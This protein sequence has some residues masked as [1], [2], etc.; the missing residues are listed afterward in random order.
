M[1]MLTHG[2]SAVN[3]FA[4]FGKLANFI[5]T[6]RGLHDKALGF[7]LPLLISAINYGRAS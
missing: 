4:I 6:R 2:F 1:M 3:G 7:Y 5:P